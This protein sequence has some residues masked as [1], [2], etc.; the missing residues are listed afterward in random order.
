MALTVEERFFAKVDVGH[1]LGCWEWTAATS[2]AGYGRFREG[3]DHEIRAHRWSYAFFYGTVPPGCEPDHLCRNTSC[4]N[5][6]HLEA[7]T[8]HE[9]LMRGHGASAKNARKTHCPQGHAYNEHASQKQD[10][11]RRCKVCHRDRERQRRIR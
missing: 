8:H 5:P 10:G 11:S 3:P 2:V 1:P 9:N 4:V 7:V 6:D